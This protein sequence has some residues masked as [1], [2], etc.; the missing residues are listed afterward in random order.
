MLAVDICSSGDGAG[1][2]CSG[3]L[4]LALVLSFLLILPAVAEVPFA[5]ASEARAGGSTSRAIRS[6]MAN[7]AIAPRMA[8]PG[9]STATGPAEDLPKFVIPYQIVR[10]NGTIAKTSPDKTAAGRI[11]G[12]GVKVFV[13]ARRVIQTSIKDP[14]VVWLGTTE[15]WILERTGPA[16][17]AIASGKKLLLCL[18][19]RC[20]LVLG[21]CW[22]CAV[23]DFLL[24]VCSSLFDPCACEVSQSTA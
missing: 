9:A 13:I 11:L 22:L 23:V 19:L 8:A 15:G 3:V 10:S 7:S 4:V 17:G 1:K 5:V 24:L 14:P 12:H 2:A 18:L 16:T 6:S 21:V 20:S